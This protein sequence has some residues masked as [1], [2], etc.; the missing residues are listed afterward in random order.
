MGRSDFLYPRCTLLRETLAGAG[1]PFH[2][3]EDDSAHTWRAWRDY[4]LRFAPL[5]F[6]AP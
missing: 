5:L 2:Y 1:V 4:F 3:H 6:R